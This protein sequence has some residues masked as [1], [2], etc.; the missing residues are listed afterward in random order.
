MGNPSHPE[1]RRPGLPAGSAVSLVLAAAALCLAAC[2]QTETGESPDA[3]PANPE[4]NGRVAG[5][6]S[7]T[8]W[9]A[10]FG[11]HQHA[12]EWSTDTALRIR[13]FDVVTETFPAREVPATRK[14][15]ARLYPGS[16]IPALDSIRSVSWSFGETDTLV[17]PFDS[18]PATS[19]ASA[20]TVS[21]NVHLDLHPLHGMLYGLRY[22]RRSRRIIDP[23]TSGIPEKTIYLD[24]LKFFFRGSTSEVTSLLPPGAGSHSEI[25]FY[26]PGT[27]SFCEAQP[28]SFHLGPLP[29][30]Q[31]PLRV[32]RISGSG[33]PGAETSVEA[34][35]LRVSGLGTST[36]F[37][38]GERVLAFPSPG[39]SAL[40][41]GK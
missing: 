5:A 25:S 32:L 16:V 6:P 13:F 35:E 28:D 24:S 29:K 22:S 31:Y 41:E 39:A 40:R 8:N 21:F 15:I 18:I 33:I 2:L 20:D 27:P 30:G 11:R 34:W 17:I 37:S 23:P 36:K 12:L 10:E 1:S 38:L 9:P 14:G 7:S 26:I 3:A 19:A 4:D